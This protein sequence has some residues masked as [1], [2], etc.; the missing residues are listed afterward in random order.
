MQTSYNG[1]PVPT[2]GQAI[3]YNSGKFTIP[4]V[5]CGGSE[6]LWWEAVGGVV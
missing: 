4:D 6:G 3:E 5:R 1:I 2:N